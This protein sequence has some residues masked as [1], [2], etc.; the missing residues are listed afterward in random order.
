MP[1]LLNAASRR[2]NSS[3]AASDERRNVVGRGHVRHERLGL[4]AD[5]RDRGRRLE[6]SRPAVEVAQHERR[7]PLGE[8][9]RGRTSDARGRAR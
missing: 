5:A 7:P 6:E 8:L 4:N 3:T 9:H 2:P 1:A